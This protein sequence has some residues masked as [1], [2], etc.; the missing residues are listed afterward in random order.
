MLKNTQ[1]LGQL[2]ALLDA[3]LHGNENLSITGLNTLQNAK[4]GELAFLANPNYQK[5][6]ASTQASAVILKPDMAKGFDGNKLILNN[7]YLGYAKLTALFL[8]TSP[9]Q[10]LHPSSVIHPEATVA[11][12]ASIGANSVIEA[13][14]EIGAG[15]VIGAGCYVGENSIIGERTHLYANVTI[16]HE[17]TIGSDSILHSSSVIGADGFG[18]APDAGRWVKIHQLGGVVIGDRVEVGAGTTI[19]RGALDDTVIGD[20]VILDNQVQIAHNVR[21]GENSAIAGCTAVAGSTTIGRN[22]TI[23]GGCCIVG[24]LTLVDKVHVTAMTLV[25]KSIRQPGAY[26]SGT[27]MSESSVW[28]KNAV[29]FGQLNTMAGRL[30]V[31]EKITKTD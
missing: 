13:G 1:P 29:R 21:I 14:C 6:L 2:A 7:P 24:H 11:S 25:T 3:E 17:V 30:K 20:G 22:C 18:F 26:S 12:D 28:R 10:G 16:Y 19:D 4:S 5:Y 15:A 27:P 9:S 8:N 23:S 31:L